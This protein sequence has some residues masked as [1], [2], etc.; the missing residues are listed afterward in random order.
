MTRIADWN[1]PTAIRFGIGRIDEL[2]DG[3]RELGMVRPILITDQGL[4][5]FSMVT[6]AIAANRAAGSSTGESGY[7]L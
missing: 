5:D 7:L 2:A 6:D 4:V 1:Y 3:C